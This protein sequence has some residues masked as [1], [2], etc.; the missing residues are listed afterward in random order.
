MAGISI[1]LEPVTDRLSQQFRNM[2]IQT[3]LNNLLESPGAKG[4]MGGALSGAA[5]SL[6]MN[7]SAR[8]S[9][10]KTAVN[11]GGAAALAGI[12]YYA[13]KKWQSSKASP[14]PSTSGVPAPASSVVSSPPSVK[15]LAEALPPSVTESLAGKMVRAMIATAMADDHLDAEQVQTI[16][17]A[18]DNPDLAPEEVRSLTASLRNPATAE[19]IA[20][21]IANLEEASEV[22]GACLTVLSQNNI[23]ENVFL[24][25]LARAMK[26]PP[27]LVAE[28]QKNGQT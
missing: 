18:L 1:Q 27:E 4:A 9:L 22:Y 20:A 7:K 19:Q 16:E 3:F 26:L 12:G 23:A 6:L 17:D 13:Y 14:T 2:S 25:R 10:G 21:D 24:R 8:K 15:P 28:I 5:V 11:I